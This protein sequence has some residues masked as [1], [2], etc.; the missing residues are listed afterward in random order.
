MVSTMYVVVSVF[1]D[2]EDNEREG[3]MGLYKTLEGARKRLTQIMEDNIKERIESTNMG[4]A[5]I[6]SLVSMEND[7]LTFDSELYGYEFGN[8]Y[9]IKEVEVGE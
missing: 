7:V 4:E 2:W 9:R 1:T 3:F 6:R 8:E 5:E